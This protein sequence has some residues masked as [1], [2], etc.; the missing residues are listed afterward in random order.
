MTAKVEL[1]RDP[2]HGQ[3]VTRLPAWI[4][5][6]GGVYWH[7]PR[8]AR[9]RDGSLVV[10]YW[11]GQMARVDVSRLSEEPPED[12]KC[13]TCLGRR[14][15][16]D[17]VDGAV[18]HPRDHWRLPSRCPGRSWEAPDFKLCIACGERV[19][20]A[21]GWN[22]WGSAKHRAGPGLTERL[23]PCPRHGWKDIYHAG[24]GVFP[25]RSWQC[26]WVA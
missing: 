19:R 18:F 23:R 4:A 2:G 12:L 21:Q 10:D 5:P 15:G 20:A 14:A 1:F 6:R 11:C 25:C 16:F 17:R 9:L 24:D 8:S 3:H 22:A 7:Q 13:G 26:G